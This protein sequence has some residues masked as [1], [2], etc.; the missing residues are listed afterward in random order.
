MPHTH[1]VRFWRPTALDTL[2]ASFRDIRTC[3][4]AHLSAFSP[5]FNVIVE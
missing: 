1:F 4:C 2:P 5:S 3:R